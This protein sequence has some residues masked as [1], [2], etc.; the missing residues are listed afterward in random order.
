[1]LDN[2]SP[3]PGDPSSRLGS[4]RLSTWDCTAMAVSVI[5]PAMAFTYNTSFAAS[6]SGGSTPLAFLLGGVACFTVALVVIGFCRKMAAAGYAYTFTSRAIGPAAG[7]LMGWI[8]IFAMFCFISMPIGGLGGFTSSLLDDELH[9]HVPWFIVFLVALGLIVTFTVLDVKINARIQLTIG[10]ATVLVVLVFAGLEIAHAGLH[11][12]TAAPFTFSHTLQ[13][14]FKGIFYGL[15]FGVLSYVGFETAAVLGEETKNPLKAIPKSV[16]MA[17]VF[18]IVFY[19]V[20]TYALTLGIGVNNGDKWAADPTIV[21]HEAERVGGHT[22]AVLIEL[23]AILSAFVFGLAAMT[24]VTRTLFAMG[25]ERALP[26]WFGQTNRRFHTPSN[27]AFVVASLTV[28]VTVLVGFVWDYGQGSFQVY[29]L[30]AAIGGLSFTVVYLV[31]CVDGM[32]WFRKT[33][34]KYNLFVHGVLPG[35]GLIIFICAIYG[36]VY[37]VPPMPTRLVPYIILAWLL[38]GA[39]IIVALRRRQPDLI[40]EI[41]QIAAE[42]GAEESM[43]D[44]GA[45]SSSAQRL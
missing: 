32:I 6:A 25:R 18:A 15:I 17:T 34:L 24:A 27:A 33:H 21:A 12:Q 14:G 10:V 38:I 28:V 7:F 36:S 43:E 40:A 13:G 4:G 2:R 41:G 39:A 16:I 45:V 31:L 29:G 19:T 35:A 30:F 9:V 26:A 5:A 23:G 1:M 22:L 37:P 3:K 42:E 11:G 20:T 8:Y 44:E